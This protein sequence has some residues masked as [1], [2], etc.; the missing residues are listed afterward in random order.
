[1]RKIGTIYLVGAGPGPVDLLTLR[2]ARLISDARVIV[3]DG[4]IGPDILGLARPDARLIS[5][6][7]QRARHTMPQEAINAL[8]IR[9][10]L[11]GNDVVRLKGGD[12][13]IFGRGGENRAH[14]S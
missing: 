2:A 1:M 14:T 5:V 11:S 4:L 10:A 6:A 3:H 12:P 8:L 7:K 13:F 9:E